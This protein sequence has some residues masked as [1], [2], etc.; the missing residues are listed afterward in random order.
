MPPRQG[1]HLV[2]DFLEK[3]YKSGQTPVGGDVASD[4][5]FFTLGKSP[6]KPHVSNWADQSGSPNE[7]YSNQFADYA[8]NSRYQLPSQHNFYSNRAV[9]FPSPG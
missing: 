1:K 4:P 9:R 3:C 2:S 8:Q 5:H 6:P 7:M